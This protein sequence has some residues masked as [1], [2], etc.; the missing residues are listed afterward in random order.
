MSIAHDLRREIENG[1]QSPLGLLGPLLRAVEDLDNRV[2]ANS[3][4]LLVGAVSLGPGHTCWTWPLNQGWGTC[5]SH[6]CHLPLTWL[7]SLV[8]L[9]V[10]QLLS[11]V[12]RNA[13]QVSVPGSFLILCTLS[14]FLSFSMWWWFPHHTSSDHLS[15][16]G[17]RNNDLSTYQMKVLGCHIRT[18]NLICPNLNSISYPPN[19]LL[20]LD[21]LCFFIKSTKC[22]P[23][24]PNQ[25]PS[26]LVSYCHNNTV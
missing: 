24:S 17:Y 3:E 12:K 5:C 10:L 20:F 8:L 16:V 13:S 14:L 26:V 9:K 7:W 21:S 22:L 18:S 15:I 2:E 19:L 4:K 23:S 6:L 11:S 1:L 25:Y